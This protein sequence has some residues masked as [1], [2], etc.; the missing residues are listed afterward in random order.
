LKFVVFPL[1]ALMLKVNFASGELAEAKSEE[2]A[3]FK[4]IL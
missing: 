3:G 1:N 2:N 4:D